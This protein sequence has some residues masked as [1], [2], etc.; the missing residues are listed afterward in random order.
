M[1]LHEFIQEVI[2]Y[3]GVWDFELITDG[4]EYILDEAIVITKTKKIHLIFAE[5]NPS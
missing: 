4:D 2:K 3:E 5:R 1:T